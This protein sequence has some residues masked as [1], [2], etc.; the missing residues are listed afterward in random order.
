LRS[1]RHRTEP[2]RSASWVTAPTD[3]PIRLSTL[4]VKSLGTYVDRDVR[5]LADLGWKKFI[6]VRRGE[7]DLSSAVDTLPHPA[8]SHLRHLRR[9]GARAPMSTAPWSEERLAATMARGPHKSAFEYAEF[10][11]EELV[12]FVLKGQWVVL[13]YSVVQT[14]PRQVRRQ[15]RISPMGVVLQ[16][17]RRPHVIV[18]YSFFGV[19]DETVKLAPREAMQFGKA[20]ERILR[21]IVEADPSHGPV[22]LLKIDIADGFYRIWLNKHDIL[23]LAV[24]LPPLHGDWRHTI[25]CTALSSP[26]GLDRVSAIFHHSNG[27]GGRLG[28]SAHHESVE[29]APAQAVAVGC[30]T[31]TYV[32]YG[33]WANGHGRRG[34]SPKC[35]TSTASPLSAIGQCRCLCRRLHW[36]LPRIPTPPGCS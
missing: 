6:Q 21:N 11:G 13:P 18:D 27:D 22:Y 23:S 36:Q 19:N 1:K 9:R 5:L 25:G 30:H 10:L 12:E 20:L 35:T 4:Q 33:I 24:S 14:L 31:T 29:S 8:R 2:P 28:K 34:P 26:H 3:G 32:N 16:R 15:L 7:S 17:E